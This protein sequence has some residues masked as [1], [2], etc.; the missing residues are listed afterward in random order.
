MGDT[1]RFARELYRFR[2]ATLGSAAFLLPL[3]AFMVLAVCAS[4]IYFR[5]HDMTDISAG[6]ILG[7]IL[8]IVFF[9]L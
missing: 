8:G 3:L 4:R 1:K 2:L 6:L 7:A 5:R 9:F